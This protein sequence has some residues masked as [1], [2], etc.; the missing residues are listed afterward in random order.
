MRQMIHVMNVLGLA[1]LI[2][3]VNAE[4]G[5]AQ[6]PPPPP[7][8]AQA[9]LA[10]LLIDMSGSMLDPTPDGVTK[11]DVALERANQFLDEVRTNREYA[12]WTFTNT[13][14]TP[15]ITFAQHATAEQVRDALPALASLGGSTP[16]AGSFCDAVDYL[17]QT[18]V[19]RDANTPP[20][21]PAVLYEKRVAVYTDG[22]ENW[23]PTSHSCWGFRSELDQPWTDVDS[24]QWKIYNKA[25]TGNPDSPPSPTLPVTVIADVSMIFDQFIP[26]TFR[27]SFAPQL[28]TPA[29]LADPTFGK[30]VVDASA[31]T[32]VKDRTL[33]Q[34]IQTPDVLKDLK[35]TAIAPI[36]ASTVAMIGTT[37]VK[38]EAVLALQAYGSLSRR[39]GGEFRG[40]TRLSDVPVT[41]DA[42]GDRCVD[43]ADYDLVMAQYGRNVGYNAPADLNRDR[44]VNYSDYLSLLQNWGDGC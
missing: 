27:A 37:A 26:S 23:T 2:A 8:P 34:A 42:N 13:T 24:W 32:R 20:G 35:G 44:A 28:S 36:G 16:F 9:E 14:A 43:L 11:F 10:L 19:E 18:Q 41:G 6:A 29:P 3:A 33:V 4:Q 1:A 5:F 7:P 12:L 22:L 15:V 30:G 25:S 39:T 38:T 21:V 17:M 31:L 40:L